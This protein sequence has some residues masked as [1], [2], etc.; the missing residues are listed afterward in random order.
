MSLTHR[1]VESRSADRLISCPPAGIAAGPARPRST[2]SML[3]QALRPGAPSLPFSPSGKCRV[4][5]HS[6]SERSR[7]CENPFSEKVS[8]ERVP[9]AETPLTTAL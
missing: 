3:A 6:W 1:W 7:A 9:F 2:R 4:Y 8:T 5:L